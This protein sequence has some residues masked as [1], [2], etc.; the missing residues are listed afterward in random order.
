M[1]ANT[2]LQVSELNFFD[3]KNNLKNFLRSN[4][5]FS[6]YDFEGTAMSTMLDVLAYNTYYNSFYVNMVANESFLDSAMM[7]E[8][9]YSISKMLNYTP[10]SSRSAKANITI[11]FSPTDSPSEIVI[12]AS[13]KFTAKINNVL[14]EFTTNADYSVTPTNGA[15]IKSIDIYEGTTLEY[16]FTVSDNVNFYEMTAKG[17]DTP[18]MIV[19]VSPNLSSSISTFYQRVKDT[20]NV[21]ASSEI[22]YLQKNNR[23]NYEIYFGDGVL[24]KKL[25]NG[26]V[27]RILVRA[28]SGSAANGAQAFSKVGFAGYSKDI[29]TNRY[30]CNIL[31][32]NQRA[33]DGEDDETIDSIKFNAPRSYE[34][35]NR[36]I[37]AEDYINFILENY[38][39]IQSI[40]VWGGETHTPPMY[41]KTIMSIKPYSGYVITNDRKQTIINEIEKYTPM[42]IDPVIIDPAFIFVKPNIRINYNPNVTSLAA[43]EIF[44]KIETTVQKYE[45]TQLGI[46]GNR[47]KLSKFTA[48]VDV[49]DNS[50][51][52]SDIEINLEKRFAPII[53]SKFTYKLEFQNPLYN[54]Y[55]GY[56]GCVSSSG[57][58]IG[59][60][61]RTLY[62]DDDGKGVLRLYYYVGN[63]KAYYNNNVGTVVYSTGVVTLD[64][65]VFLDYDKEV[66]IFVKPDTTDIF[67]YQNN[68]ILLSH[69]DVEMYDITRMKVMYNKTVEVLGNNTL[70]D[71][72]GVSNTVTL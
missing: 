62:L 28:C 30:P 34:I 44:S 54:P 58:K 27:V 67:S 31:S 14:Y 46:F 17:I 22:Y 32:V 57:F 68:I 65:F 47:F 59:G 12:P 33:V 53:G 24:G 61:D 8:S 66:S 51:E 11:S 64:S 18:S 71:V 4:S 63:A 26:N 29:P 49:S 72:N 1:T 42:S 19:T 2:T 6:D 48:M 3:I 9:V 16:T 13:T 35:Q 23:G 56:Q 45:D 60:S 10:R 38:S 15:Y 69:P 55:S 43:D 50:I 37:T 70:I 20:T 25:T 40:N 52:S 41:G 39:D 7:P 21:T 36:L 5:D